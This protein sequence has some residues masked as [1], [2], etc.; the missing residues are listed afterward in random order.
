M[1]YRDLDRNSRSKALFSAAAGLEPKNPDIRAALGWASLRTRELSAARK[2]FDEA[3]ELS[4]S[5]AAALLGSARLSL[6]SRDPRGAL[7]RLTRLLAARPEFTLAH[8]YSGRAYEATG[9]TRKAVKAYTDAFNS[10]W[11]YTETRLWLGPLYSKLRRFNDAWRQFTK[12]LQVAPHNTLARRQKRLL[13]KRITKKP[14]QILPSR[15]LKRH[16]PVVAA[17]RTIGPVLRI[18]VGTTVRGSP[19]PKKIVAFMCSGEFEIIDPETG[20]RLARGPANQAWIARRVGTSRTYE[21][22]DHLKRRKLRFRRVIAVRPRKPKQHSFIFQRLNIA[23]GTAWEAQG[24]RQLKGTVELRAL[25]SRGV[26]L[27][28]VIPLEEY[29]Y[30]VVNEEMPARYPMEALKAQAV[31]ARTH[32]VYVKRHM[33]RH[34]RYKYDLCDGQHCQVYSGV[35]GENKRGRKAADGTRGLVLV[36]GKRLAH[37]PYMSNCGGHTQ[38]SA[39]MTGWGKMPYL[40]GREDT[41][42]GETRIKSPWELELWMKSAPKVFCN[43]PKYMHSSQFRWSRVLPA[44]DLGDRIRRRNRRFGY[45]RA[46]RVLRRSKS[47][48][49]NKLLFRGTRGRHVED[50]EHRIRGIM[51]LSSARSTMFIIETDRNSKGVPTEFHLYGGGWGHGTGLCQIGAAGR[52]SGGQSYKQIL[53]HYYSGTALKALGR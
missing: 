6:L 33:R 35:T 13:A 46:I 18:G 30:G 23:D 1:V 37:T 3:L 8:V 31:I 47:G 53:A 27:I 2:A 44:N 11:T 49:V 25:S 43:V 50:K 4:P 45:L 52:A 20:R 34:T 36:H 32:A 5:H 51:G 29:V 14:S 7:K 21:V 42:E 22:V 17:R 9:N 26:Y 39:E 15:K 19:A 41:A 48:N 16:L 10:D 12:V 38:D 40:R 28:N 24:D